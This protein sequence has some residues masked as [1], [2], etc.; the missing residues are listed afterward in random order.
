MRRGTASRREWET[1]RD[2]AF[3]ADA[4]LA[5][6][7]R[8][9]V[10]PEPITV[11]DPGDRVG[12]QV[13]T[14]KASGRVINAVASMLPGLLG[15]SADLEPSTNTLIDDGGDLTS[16]TPGGRNIRF[17]VREHAMGAMVNG[18]NLHGGVRAFGSTF[19]V[20]SD[21]MRPALRLSALMGVPSIWVYTHD[22]VFLG[23]DGPTHQPI[24]HLASLRAMPNLWVLRPADAGETAEA[25]EV[26]L[27]RSDG[28]TALVLTRQSVP[29]LERPRGLVHRG[30]YVLVEGDDAV[31]VATGSEVWV[32]AEASRILAS[33][34]QSVR[35]VSL[36]CREAFL[37][38]DPQ[39]RRAVL[40]DGLP[41]AT[42]EAG[43]TW[44]W[45]QIA[46]AD[47]LLIGID[48][49]GASAPASRLAE[50]W[51]FTPAAVAARI[52]EWLGGR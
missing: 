28:P 16:T 20:F 8:R 32:A 37:A 42:L 34:G 12:E 22:S 21:Y 43:A 1:R 46:G 2:A 5:E 27:H 13:A 3:S 36:P 31:I 47:G 19:L 24:E 15:G 14:R 38:Q 29:V 11:P 30:G 35:V 52:G 33:R 39:Y 49:F 48:H 17:G 18:L 40:G 44:G 10:A 25:W 4:D 45:E 7:W 41:V 50:E 9:R 26:A 51:G 6:R 23:E